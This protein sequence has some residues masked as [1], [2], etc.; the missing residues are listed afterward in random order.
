MDEKIARFLHFLK[1]DKAAAPNTVVAYSSDL[2]Q[3]A[4]YLR[5]LEQV[6]IDGRIVWSRVSTETILGYAKRL[7]AANLAETTIARRTAAIKSFFSHLHD[8]GYVK[9]D[10]GFGL[11]NP[12]INRLA[13]Q[14]L[15]KHEVETLLAQ[16]HPDTP[17]GMRD[18][19]MLELMYETGLRNS[20][21]VALWVANVNLSEQTVYCSGRGPRERTLPLPEKTVATIVNYLENGRPRLGRRPKGHPLFVNCR[22]EQFTRQGFWLILKQHAQA[23][24]LDAR[25]CPSTLRDSF[26]THLLQ[27]GVPTDVVRQRL[28]HANVSTTRVYASLVAA[29]QREWFEKAHPGSRRRAVPK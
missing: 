18:R 2:H 21:L 1:A 4:T 13:P 5:E 24:Q 27:S 9:T 10:P 8:W 25:V 22:G 14:P 16:P 3:F 11:P 19:A 29:Q 15:T 12:R 6:H 17:E 7:R 23:A 26:A 28:G 20:E